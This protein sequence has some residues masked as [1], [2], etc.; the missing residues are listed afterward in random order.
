M[1]IGPW[2]IVVSHF[3]RPLAEDLAVEVRE[4]ENTVE[5]RLETAT[6][7]A[8]FIDEQGEPWR[9]EPAWIFDPRDNAPYA[10][11]GACEVVE[12]PDGS[13]S[14]ASL[15]GDDSSVSTDSDGRARWPRL[16]AG[17]TLALILFAEWA[18]YSTV[19]V[20][21]PAPGESLDLG[22]I[23]VPRVGQ[24]AVSFDDAHVRPKVLRLL[25]VKSGSELEAYRWDVAD[26]DYDNGYFNDP[27]ANWRLP[28]G[29]YRIVPYG[30]A[31]PEPERSV[32]LNVVL[33]QT[34]E[35]TL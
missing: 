11:I 19:E 25:D 10:D 16:P 21:A 3:H 18:A 30:E 12:R 23:I 7:T 34:T 24:I 28:A 13:C 1:A 15:C 22:D 17:R 27:P 32:E 33:G 8:R 6:V 29:H 14:Y 5:I 35:V 31:G 4:G 2:R 26:D 9:N 20:P